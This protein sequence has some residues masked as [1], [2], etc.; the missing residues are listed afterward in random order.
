MSK[1]SAL[2]LVLSVTALVSI[3]MVMLFSTG[4][5]AH[6]AHGDA[7]FFIKRQGAFLAVGIVACIFAAITDYH[8]WSKLWLPIFVGAAGLLVLCFVP[9]IGQ[10]VHGSSRWVHVGSM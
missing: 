10:S 4:A 2:I 7:Y 3:G 6:D 9:H 1:N 8:I 5:Y